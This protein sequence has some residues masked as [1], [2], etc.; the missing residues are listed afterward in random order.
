MNK[1]YKIISILILLFTLASCKNSPTKQI[2]DIYPGTPQESLK[3]DTIPSQT[4]LE[5]KAH[6]VLEVSG[7]QTSDT[8]YEK[9]SEN[10]L[11]TERQDNSKSQ[12]S[13]NEYR[14]SDSCNISTEDEPSQL[15]LAMVSN[16]VEEAEYKQDNIED[17]ENL[18]EWLNTFIPEEVVFQSEDTGEV[19]EDKVSKNCPVIS[20]DE[21][22]QLNEL[23]DLEVKFK[24]P[25]E[26]PSGEGECRK[27]D[28]K[29]IGEA[30]PT[31]L[32]T[33]ELI[34]KVNKS[35]ADMIEKMLNEGISCDEIMEKAE[36]SKLTENNSVESIR[37]INIAYDPDE[38]YILYKITFCYPLDPEDYKETKENQIC[39]ELQI[40]YEPNYF[41]K[42]LTLEANLFGDNVYGV[43]KSDNWYE[44]EI[45][46]FWGNPEYNPITG[47]DII[48]AV[49]DAGADYSCQELTENIIG[50]WNFV[51][52]N[53][54]IMDH[55][56][57]DGH[58]TNVAR[59][60][61]KIAPE[62]KLMIIKAITPDGG[63]ALNIARAIGYAVDNGA[64]IINLSLGGKIESVFIDDAIDYAFKN[65]CVIIAAAGNSSDDIPLFPAKNPKVISVMSSNMFSNRTYHTNKGGDSTAP[66]ANIDLGDC[67][68]SGTSFSTPFVSGAVARLLSKI[69]KDSPDK[70]TGR[71]HPMTILFILTYDAIDA[72]RGILNLPNDLFPQ[73]FILN[74]LKEGIM[75]RILSAKPKEDEDGIIEITAVAKYF[76]STNYIYSLDYAGGINAS[77]KAAWKNIA[78]IHKNE[79][80]E[81]DKFIWD[82]KGIPGGI[83]TIRLIGRDYRK[84]EILIDRII[85][86]INNQ[87]VDNA[88][89]TEFLFSPF[90]K[91]GNG[92]DARIEID[93]KNK[94][95]EIT[96]IFYNWNRRLGGDEIRSPLTSV[97]NGG[98]KFKIDLKRHLPCSINENEYEGPIGLEVKNY[99]QDISIS[100]KLINAD[101]DVVYYNDDFNAN[102]KM[103][104]TESD[105]WGASWDPY[106]STRIERDEYHNKYNE[107][108]RKVEEEKDYELV[109]NL[110]NMPRITKEARL[111]LYNPTDEDG[112]VNIT[113]FAD[114]EMFDT[115]YTIYTPNWYLFYPLG[116][117]YHLY[118][119][120]VAGRKS[121]QGPY[122]LYKLNDRRRIIYTETPEN[123]YNKYSTMYT[124][125]FIHVYS[126]LTKLDDYNGENCGSY[127]IKWSSLVLPGS[128]SI[129]ARSY[130]NI[131]AWAFID[132]GGDYEKYGNSGRA[133]IDYYCA[134]ACM[135]T[136]VY[137]KGSVFG[138]I[139]HEK[140]GTVE[141][142]IRLC[143][144]QDNLLFS[145]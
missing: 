61:N 134:N 107:W 7:S 142:V 15:Q 52:D 88:V 75:C 76:S 132:K 114:G 124:P 40:V 35:I 109:S 38:E 5:G 60:I 138:A 1:I 87:L 62:C 70:R 43:F 119:V 68:I 84:N 92:Y 55:D 8:S 2:K 74:C 129:P 144:S 72:N 133:P 122:E 10:L 49:I 86:K 116:R 121:F 20:A 97:L 130:I 135:V 118:K 28:H 73:E 42:N 108:C 37:R 11:T 106:V 91:I 127:N 27:I 137:P 29:S 94:E 39:N 143:P 125:R 115:P 16:E 123:K 18:K 100:L 110:K 26:K 53:N 104:N 56:G 71:I 33:Y 19:S 111:V 23:K 34:I 58:G 69:Y 46:W 63:E 80:T 128:I 113:F 51:D 120:R 98:G 17:N 83:Y 4:R 12:D 140:D 50:G 145:N 117:D 64:D 59:I 96:P 36:L 93:S 105:F 141:K 14:V 77:G 81:N 112:C 6:G 9:Q 85:V 90:C 45:D 32:Q 67:C 47:E 89:N 82:T 54:D 126:L 30:F 131:P 44:K 24:E 31:S 3:L 95:V 79:I 99:S 102:D 41:I 22:I 136:N 78:E 13:V 48:I 25:D 103:K 66:G 139:V 21:A 65:K 57:H 101:S